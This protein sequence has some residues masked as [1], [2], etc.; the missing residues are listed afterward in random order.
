MFETGRFDSAH[1]QEHFVGEFEV[2]LK[3]G[4]LSGTAFEKEAKI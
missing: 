4:V 3:T 2:R 1:Y